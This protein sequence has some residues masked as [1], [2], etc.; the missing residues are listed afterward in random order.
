MSHVSYKYDYILLYSSE[1]L[2]QV[3][4][5]GVQVQLVTGDPAFLSLQVQLRVCFKLYIYYIIILINL[6]VRKTRGVYWYCAIMHS[7]DF[8]G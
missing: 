5:S 4:R 2:R 1:S 3:N 7:I 6:C 8:R